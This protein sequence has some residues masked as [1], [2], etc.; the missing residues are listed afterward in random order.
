MDG[1]YGE[2]KAV[3]RLSIEKKKI[4]CG[5]RREGIRCATNIFFAAQRGP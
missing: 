3:R 4:V 5:G 1:V 2:A